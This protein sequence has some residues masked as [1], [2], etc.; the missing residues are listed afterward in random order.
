M[1]RILPA[2]LLEE[3]AMCSREIRLFINPTSLSECF[4]EQSTSLCEVKTA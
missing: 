3:T 4:I 1:K 2:I